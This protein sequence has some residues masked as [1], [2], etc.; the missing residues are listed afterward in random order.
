MS[1]TRRSGATTNA[2]GD[3][4]AARDARPAGR[5]RTAAARGAWAVGSVF[6]AI[7]RLIRLLVGIVFVIIVAAILLRVFNANPTNTI[8]KDVHD[9]AKTLVGPFN[10]LFH[11]KNPK[12]SIAV[13][14]G[15]AALVWLVVGNLIASLI[16]RLAPRGAAPGE[17]VV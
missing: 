9:L 7:S 13:N 1:A 12:A 14:W 17:P 16:A 6:L 3:D 15:I 2:A 4:V 5:G 10:N 8:V 11:I